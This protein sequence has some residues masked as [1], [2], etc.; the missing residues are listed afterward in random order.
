VHSRPF[1]CHRALKSN[2][3]IRSS[4]RVK[5]SAVHS[6]IQWRSRRDAR[7]TIELQYAAEG[8]T[9]HCTVRVGER[10]E[11]LLAIDY[12]LLTRSLARCVFAPSLL[13]LLLVARTHTHTH[14]ATDETVSGREAVK[15]REVRRP[16]PLPPRLCVCII[17]I[18]G[19]VNSTRSTHT[20]TRAR[21]H[22]VN[23]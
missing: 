3:L 6:S 23:C 1:G 7:C 20:H 2:P 10:K 18:A 15:E 4:E 5:R 21:T 8:R 17:S 19:N 9:A 12:S 14:T 13:L 22:R 16:L 11:G